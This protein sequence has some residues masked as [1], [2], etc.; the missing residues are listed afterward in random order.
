MALAARRFVPTRKSPQ[1]AS[2]GVAKDFPVQVAKAAPGPQHANTQPNSPRGTPATA[3]GRQPSAQTESDAIDAQMIEQSGAGV[4]AAKSR[5]SPR[6]HVDPGN[7]VTGFGSYGKGG[8][9]MV[10]PFGAPTKVHPK[11]ATMPT[12]AAS[13]NAKALPSQER[14]RDVSQASLLIFGPHETSATAKNGAPAGSIR[15]NAANAVPT[16][17]P[18][19]VHAR[20]IPADPRKVPS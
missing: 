2:R 10:M 3:V 12:H 1:T 6:P 14:P 15:G 19:K 11:Q 8:R 5:L 17:R 9:T 18:S 4:A 7:E 20:P 13:R 16:K